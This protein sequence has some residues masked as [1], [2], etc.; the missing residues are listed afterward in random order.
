MGTPKLWGL[1]WRTWKIKLVA[2]LVG[3]EYTMPPFTFGVT[4]KLPEYLEMN[5]HGKV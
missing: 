5:P 1:G 3:F 2:E 4:N